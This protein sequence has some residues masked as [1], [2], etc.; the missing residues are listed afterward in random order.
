MR[1]KKLLTFLTLLTLFFTTAWAETAT[2]EITVDNTTATTNQYAAF[3]YTAPS[4]AVYLGYTAKGN[5]CM[6][7]N[8][9][10]GNRGIVVGTSPGKA[11]KVTITWNDNTSNGRSIQIWGKNTAYSSSADL[12][13]TNKK[14]SQIGTI[15]KGTSTELTISDDYAYIAFYPSAAIYVEKIEVTWDTS[16]GDD[17]TPTTYNLIGDAEN[18]TIVFTVDGNAVTKAAAGAAV[19]VTATANSGYEFDSWT[20]PDIND[21]SVNNEN[22]NI[23]TFTMPEDN[24]TVGA[25][26]TKTTPTGDYLFYESFD[27]ISGTGGNDGNWSGITSSTNINYANCDNHETGNLWS[28]AKGTVYTGSQC[29]R[30]A[31]ASGITTPSISAEENV[32]YTMSFKAASWSNDGTTLNLSA[33]GATLYSD[34]ACNTELSQLTMTKGSW[35]THTIYVKANSNSTSYKVSFVSGANIRWF[36]D[37]VMVMEPA[38]GAHTIIVGDITGEGTI[39]ADPSIQ[40]SGE[41]VTVTAKPGTGYELTALA[42]NGNLITPITPGNAES[43]YTFIMLDEDVTLT[44]TFSKIKYTI[45]TAVSTTAAGNDGCAVWMKDGFEPINNAATSTV[46]TIVEFALHPVNNWMI[47]PSNA[48]TV[49]FGEGQSVEVTAG[50]TDN[51]GAT[52]YTFTMPASNVTITGY[53]V[54]YASDVYFLEGDLSNWDNGKKMTYNSTD[55][56]YSIRVYFSDEYG[57]FRFRSGNYTYASGAE[58]DWWPISENGTGESHFGD[59]ITLYQGSSKRFRV[60]AGIYDIVVGQIYDDPTT[61]ST[62]NWWGQTKVTVTKVE[63]TFTFTPAAGS[64]VYEGQEVTVNS[65]LYDLL[66]AINSTITESDVTN[67]VSLDG[68]TYSSSVAV[69]TSETTVTGK[70]TYAFIQPTAEA[71]YTVNEIP[72]GVQYELVTSN[73]DIGEGVEYVIMNKAQGQGYAMSTEQR[74]NNRGQTVLISVIDGKI[75]P[76]EDTQIVTL[77]AATDGGW[78]LKVGE[79]YLYT[80]AGSNS[81]RTGDN[82]EAT[83]QY[84]VANISIGETSHVATIEFATANDEKRYLRRNNGS[85]IFSCYTSGQQDVYLYKKGV[86]APSKPTFSP[87]SGTSQESSISVTIS[88]SDEGT[89]YYMVNPETVPTAGATIVSDGTEYSEAITL[90]EVGEYTIYAAVL[91]NGITSSVASATYTITSSGVQPVEMSLAEIETLG[92]AAVGKTYT[93]TDALVAVYA[94]EDMLWCK[95]QATSIAAFNNP[96]PETYIDYMQVH[97]GADEAQQNNW[98][99]LKFTGATEAQLEAVYEAVGSIIDANTVTGK[100]IN[101]VNYTIEM[102]D[103]T[104]STT[105]GGNADKNTYCPANFLEENLFGQATGHTTTTSDKKYFFVN[106]KIQEVCEVTFAMWNGDYFVVPAANG[107]VNDSEIPGAFNVDWKYND[108]GNVSSSINQNTVYRFNAVVQKPVSSPAVEG[109]YVKVTSNTDLTDGDYLIVV[110]SEGEGR[111]YAYVFDGSLNALDA[112]HNNLSDDGTGYDIVNNTIASTDDIING[113]VFTIDVQAGTIKSA[114]GYY[115]GNTS[116]SNSLQYSTTDVYTNTISIDNDGNAVIVSSGGAYLRYNSDPKQDRFR[117]YKSGSYTDQSAIALYKKNVKATA[118]RLK[119]NNPDSPMT[120]VTPDGSYMVYPLNF[121]PNDAENNIVTAINTVDVAGNGVVKSV[122]Y[123][124]VAGMVS[125]VP[126]QG[127]NIVVTEYSDGSRST[128]KMLV[129]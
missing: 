25:T 77:E 27:N 51:E 5:N 63:P 123:V 32:V 22:N 105:T 102:S 126:F 9:G 69:S 37:E 53:F 64:T 11:K 60:P 98:V 4:G 23:A 74:D 33:E 12:Y 15:T 78:Y 39:S 119:A 21:W 31:K 84:Y 48:P 6:Q 95:D 89:I 100:V 19:T 111:N 115:I 29:A 65:N 116:N 125:D 54:P 118:P 44:A 28:T 114:S 71:E 92:T 17:P 109:D 38:A 61:S 85:E 127:V 122:K 94:N 20:A 103:M 1:M 62:P 47:D 66:H 82:L 52:H 113:A 34:A 49:T 104:L 101:G 40:T 36:L 43:T 120:G 30:M 8:N 14:G 57:Y 24:V 58:G 3:E 42:F 91:L 56:T 107:N 2:D 117:Y 108:L 128:S 7:L 129:K 67:E 55:K 88:S 86:I 80:L 70:A 73:D 106:P 87:E 10:N 50:A 26:F 93:I 35:T 110:E 72:A 16:G 41:T 112:V 99:A 18:G 121:D 68:N 97:G 75:I 76:T 59:E 90:S 96:D 79:G 124:N 83:G 13:D 45:N 81:L 46:G